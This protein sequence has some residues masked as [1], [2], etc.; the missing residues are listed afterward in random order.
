MYRLYHTRHEQLYAC[1]RFLRSINAAT[2]REKLGSNKS[3][4]AW[5]SSR[6]APAFC[7]AI[8]FNGESACVGNGVM[9]AIKVDSKQEVDAFNAK[10]I[11]LGGRCE[12]ES[13]PRG[14]GGFYGG[15]FRDLDGNKL[16]AYTPVATL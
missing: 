14:E 7:I 2:G 8:P 9:I 11:T 5:G 15:Y 3:I 4:A 1:S 12:G 10:A 16:N 6:E 13:G